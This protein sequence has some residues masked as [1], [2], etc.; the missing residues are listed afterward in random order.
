MDSP[1]LLGV[2]VN[3]AKVSQLPQSELL[4]NALLALMKGKVK[5]NQGI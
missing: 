1:K 5:N 3:S 2:T 4:I